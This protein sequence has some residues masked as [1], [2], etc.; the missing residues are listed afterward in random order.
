MSLEHIVG[1]RNIS[2]ALKKLSLLLK[3]S[4]CTAL[5]GGKKQQ[6]CWR[7]LWVPK[8]TIEPAGKEGNIQHDI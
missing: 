5:C 8:A 6:S 1:A 7:V 3:N 2:A 4:T